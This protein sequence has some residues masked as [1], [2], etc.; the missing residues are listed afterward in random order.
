MA[1][2]DA[3]LP[4]IFQLPP[5]KNFLSR[6]AMAAA[7]YTSTVTG[8]CWIKGRG[9][10]VP[11]RPGNEAIVNRKCVHIYTYVYIK[12]S[13]YVQCTIIMLCLLLIFSLH[14]VRF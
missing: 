2:M 6:T 10:L 8:G 4:F 9:S 12:K 14:R 7:A 13:T 11:N 3:L 5:T 1:S